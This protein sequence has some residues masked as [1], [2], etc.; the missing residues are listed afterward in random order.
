MSDFINDLKHPITIEGIEVADRQRSPE[1]RP[2]ITIT[3]SLTSK[4]QSECL[5]ITCVLYPNC[6]LNM[7][8][9]N[10]VINNI[11]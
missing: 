10:N 7:G 2:K 11:I 1:N 4:S 3:R 6:I 9:L 8:I 5:F